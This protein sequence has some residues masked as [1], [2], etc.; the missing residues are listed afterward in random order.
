MKQNI[1]GV[2]EFEESVTLVIPNQWL[3]E[4]YEVFDNAQDACEPQ[5]HLEMKLFFESLAEH[6]QTVMRERERTWGGS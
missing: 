3:K 1:K 6:I 4:V 5:T 2:M